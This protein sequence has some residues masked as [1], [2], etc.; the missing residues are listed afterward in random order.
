MIAIIGKHQ[1]L[2]LKRP[3]Q[4]R[5]LLILFLT[6]SFLRFSAPIRAQEFLLIHEKVGFT[7][8]LEEKI[9]YNLFPDWEHFYDAQ[10]YSL[11]PE[12]IRVQIRL[13]DR[14][15]FKIVQVAMSNLEFYQLK[16][17]IERQPALT[18]EERRKIH[19]RYQPLFIS[20]YLST[21]PDTVYCRV[22]LNS[23]ARQEG[24]LYRW[25]QEYIQI[26]S[27]K[28]LITISIRE[29]ATLKY[30]T[31]YHQQTWPFYFAAIVGGSAGYLVSSRLL[32]LFGLPR[33]EATLLTFGSIATGIATSYHLAPLINEITL[34]SVKIEFRKERIKSLDLFYRTYYNMLKVKDYLWTIFKS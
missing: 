18:D 15:D 16:A 34:P 3:R 5:G 33:S 14:S 2:N 17:A 10:F 24:I 23:G 12:S 30:W 11:N 21:I 13:W 20:K 8:D 29:I 9:H 4:K 31:D 32:S 22:K 6:G 28:K 19:K 25:N 26:W 7:L 1:S 27:A